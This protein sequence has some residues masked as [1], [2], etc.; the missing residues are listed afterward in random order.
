MKFFDSF[1]YTVSAPSSAPLNI[2]LLGFH[3]ATS[4]SKEHARF[5]VQLHNHR[6][7][8]INAILSSNPISNV[9]EEDM[10]QIGGGIQDPGAV[11]GNDTLDDTDICLVNGCQDVGALF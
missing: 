5:E 11:D 6:R 1:R 4:N 7:D 8:S 2:G 10:N 3:S 9:D